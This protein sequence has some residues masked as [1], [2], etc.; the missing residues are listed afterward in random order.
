MKCPKCGAT[1][2]PNVK[3]CKFCGTGIKYVTSCQYGDNIANSAYDSSSCHIQQYNYSY[4]YSNKTKPNYNLNQSHE[5]QYNYN[6][7][8]SNKYNYIKTE[9]IGDEKYLEVYVGQNYNIIKN[10]KFSIGTLLFGGFHLLY[11]KLYFYAILYFFI[12]I[13]ANILIPEYADIIRIIVNF[14]CAFKFNSLYMEQVEKKVEQIKQSNFDKT[15]MELLEEC[16]KQGGVSLKSAILIPIII[17]IIVIIG[18]IAIYGTKI[19]NE[20]ESYSNEE[21]VLNNNYND[22]EI[23]ADK[24]HFE[25]NQIKEIIPSTTHY[26]KISQKLNNLNYE[27]QTNFT[28]TYVH[29][30]YTFYTNYEIANNQCEIH[31]KTEAKTQG[32]FYNQIENSVYKINKVRINNKI[33]SLYEASNLD[34]ELNYYTYYYNNKLYIVQTR[35]EK[36]DYQC[37]TLQN[38]MLKTLNFAY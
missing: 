27:I 22:E 17:T 5:D 8:Y 9:T 1:L 24:T 35:A 15:S 19:I 11:R 2:Q 18:M 21:E 29:D 16:R 37:T 31:I 34:E 38:E 7:Q 33:W 13:S 10:S 23:N 4:N 20:F 25:D 28:P 14:V 3:F 36:N 30:N 32:E 6:N 12:I 26:T